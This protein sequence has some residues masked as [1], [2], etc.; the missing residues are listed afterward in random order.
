MRKLIALPVLVAIAVA[1]RI[2][3]D[4]GESWLAFHR[5]P[6]YS[7]GHVLA[8]IAP[9]ALLGAS[10]ALAVGVTSS[11][12]AAVWGVLAVCILFVVIVAAAQA[13]AGMGFL[14]LEH[15]A[16]ISLADWLPSVAFL[17]IASRYVSIGRQSVLS[18][19]A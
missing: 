16:V 13:A 14:R 3:T 19:V 15:A 10:A 2:L 4:A 1:G 9:A 8:L 11:R 5:I 12:R 7:V 6:A 18:R 17:L